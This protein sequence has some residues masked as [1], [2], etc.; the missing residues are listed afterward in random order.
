MPL[1]TNRYLNLITLYVPHESYAVNFR[2]PWLF[3]NPVDLRLSLLKTFED[4]DAYNLATLG[5][6]WR[7]P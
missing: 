3:N 6:A 1:V 5:Y 2:E 4:R 7:A